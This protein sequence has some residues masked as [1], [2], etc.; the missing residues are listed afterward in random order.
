MSSS[1]TSSPPST[2]FRKG[3]RQI[4]S[5]Q[6]EQSLNTM[7]PNPSSTTASM[8]EAA[9]QRREA[10]SSNTS[11]EE[12]FSIIQEEWRAGGPFLCVT[13]AVTIPLDE[14]DIFI[15]DPNLQKRVMREVTTITE[16]NGIS[17]DDSSPESPPM[18]RRG[19]GE[20]ETN[21]P[22]RVL[23]VGA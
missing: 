3:A 12:G 6:H 23:L 14:D 15:K 19:V 18:R 21:R 22:D 17:I 16:R 7:M 1:P 10:A 13:P 9:K 8:S 2:Q 20:P 5:E 11:S 4:S